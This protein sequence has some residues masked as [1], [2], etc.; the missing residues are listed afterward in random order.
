MT[1]I[2]VVFPTSGPALVNGADEAAMHGELVTWLV[3][4]TNPAVQSVR[5]RFEGGAN[6]FFANGAID[7]PLSAGQA[8]IWGQA[9]SLPGEDQ[10]RIDKYTVVG[11]DHAGNEIGSTENDPRIT[12]IRPNAQSG[13][14]LTRV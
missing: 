14:S 11:L 10:Y 12:T 2:N 6:V 1:E 9:P 3:S 13:T 8:A 5:L 4:S 7:K